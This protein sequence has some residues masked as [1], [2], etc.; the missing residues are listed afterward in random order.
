MKQNAECMDGAPKLRSYFYPIV[1]QSS[2]NFVAL[3]PPTFQAQ[4]LYPIV[5]VTFRL[6]NIRH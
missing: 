3:A 5:Y 2:W 6:E 4:R 1:D